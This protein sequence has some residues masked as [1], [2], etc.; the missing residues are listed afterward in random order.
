MN[1]TVTKDSVSIILNGETLSLRRGSPNFEAARAAVLN[2]VEEGIEKLFR[3]GHAVEQWLGKGY[4]L[5]EGRIMFQ[6]EALPGELSGRL[7]RMAEQKVSPAPWMKFWVRLQNNPSMRSVH[8]LYG[9]L[10]NKG[11]PIDE[12]GCILAYKA[13]RNDY[14]DYHSG[15]FSNTVGSKHSM[16]RNKISDDPNHACH[17][18]FHVGALEYARTFGGPERRILICRVDPADVVCVPYDCSM[19]KVRVCRYEVLSE[20]VEPQHLSDTYEPSENSFHDADDGDADDGFEATFE[21]YD[22][23]VEHLKDADHKNLEG[24]PDLQGLLCMKMSE[25]RVY[26]KSL[27][28]KNPGKILGGKQALADKILSTWAARSS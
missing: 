28:I 1:Y 8:Q 13:V 12:T 3:P 2:D 21:D 7:M 15:K 20:Q 18:G 27:G 9:F 16:P 25:L 26:A 5:H 24:S 22:E 23:E 19:Q 10:E 17:E 11:I 14:L 4:T 6:G